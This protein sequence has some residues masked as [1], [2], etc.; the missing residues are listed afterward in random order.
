MD[1]V[2]HIIER[3]V[4]L[5]D[6]ESVRHQVAWWLLESITGK[7]QQALIAEPVLLTD[8]QKQQLMRWLELHVDQRM[9]LQYLIGWVPFG[10]LKIL[11]EPPILIPRP[12]TE[13][14][15][16][17][18][19]DQFKRLSVTNLGILDLCTGTGCIALLLAHTLP[20]ARVDATDINPTA[21]ALAQKNSAL[22]HV[23]SIHFFHSDI[24]DHIPAASR[25]DLIVANPPYIAPAEWELLS[26]SVTLWEDKQ[27]LLAQANG[28][29]IIERIISR[30]KEFLT[31]NK[32]M[33]QRAIPQL[34]IEIGYQQGNAVH[35]LL[36]EAGFVKIAIVKD[37][38]GND[39][40]AQANL[41]PD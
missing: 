38:A 22:N 10:E 13:E 8:A 1:I 25:Y 30:A 27:A 20:M 9:P 4:P 12:E 21:L 16:L 32:Q 28:L 31:F 14:W 36:H 29:D 5:Y 18:L 15:G 37:L 41:W 40:V 2:E 26:P 17:R 33:Y 3:L 39:R 19:A 11:V 34:V 24:Y 23:N 35:Q 7:A 6:A